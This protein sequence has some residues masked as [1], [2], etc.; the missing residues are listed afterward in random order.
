MKSLLPK[1]QY[2]GEPDSEETYYG[3]G[4]AIREWAVPT[5]MEENR[6]RHISHMYVAWPSYEINYDEAVKAGAS[7][8][9]KN[10][11]RIVTADQKTQG[12]G[13]MHNALVYARLGEAENVYHSLYNVLNSNIYYSSM[14]TDHNTDR[15]SGTYCTDTGISLVAVIN[16][17]LVFSNTGEIKLLPAL[18]SEWEQGSIDGLMARTQAEVVSLVWDQETSTTDAVIKFNAAQ[19]IELSCGMAWTDVQI[20]GAE[21]IEKVSGDVLKLKV[22]AGAQV[23]VQFTM[24]PVLGKLLK[25]IEAEETADLDKDYYTE[26]TWTVYEKSLADAQTLLNSGEV[27][28]AEV[29]AAIKAIEDAKAALEEYIVEL[30]EVVADFDFD[31]DGEAFDGGY[32]QATGTYTLVE[33]GDGKALKLDGNNQ[34]LTLTT[35]EGKSLIA[36][37]DELTVSFQMKPETSST[38]WGFFVA[39]NA[40]QQNYLS[41]KYLGVFDNNGTVIAE[42]YNSN[43]QD[44]PANPSYAMGYGD[45]YYVTAV[46]SKTETILYVNGE[47][48]AREASSVDIS[49]LLGKKSVAYIGKSTWGSGECYTGLIDNYKIYSRVLTADEVAAL[50]AELVDTSALEAAIANA[51]PEAD[52]DKYTPATWETYAEA[53]TAAKDVLANEDATQAEITSAVNA[54]TSAQEKLEEKAD[55]T[56]LPYV[57]VAETDWFYDAVAYTYYE[58]VMTGMDPTHF[59]PYGQLSRAQFAL[60]L[61]RME[62]EPVVETDKKF[63]DITGDEWYGPAVLWAAEA[64]I[65]SGYLDGNFGPADMITRE[66]MAVMMYRYAKYLGQEVSADAELEKFIDGDSVSPFATDAMKWANENGIITGK[67]NGTKLDPQGNTARSEAA[68][69]IQRFM[70]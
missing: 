5:Y 39:P 45:W 44:R 55:K 13:L 4:G 47:E 54:L 67:E 49:D 28:E 37:T 17:S 19:E 1:Y 9:M 29:D 63:A 27:T 59:G 7:Q 12:H 69:I 65:V 57:D 64:E 16:E 50:A 48:V 22:D 68:V 30:P 53:L 24:D 33:H 56:K 15:S 8:A 60:I 34:F 51:V 23:T 66:Q 43:N 10:R 38:N 25:A 62:N 21:I 58:E 2:D 46:F 41:E 32:A 11:E 42:R 18:P 14:V 52:K 36:D 35:K 26:E 6:H 20:D 61:Y 40:A 70:K 3:G 31:E